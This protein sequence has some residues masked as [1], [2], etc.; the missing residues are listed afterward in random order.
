MVLILATLLAGVY[1][2]ASVGITVAAPMW[3]LRNMGGPPLVE[4]SVTLFF[5]TII[6][7]CLAYLGWAAVQLY[8]GKKRW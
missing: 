6:L 5:G 8:S 7:L 1:V 3:A 4:M 2:L